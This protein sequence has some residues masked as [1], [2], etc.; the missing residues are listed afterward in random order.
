MAHFVSEDFMVR[1]QVLV[2]IFLPMTCQPERG[3]SF[4]HHE[5][6]FRSGDAKRLRANLSQTACLTGLSPGHRSYRPDAE[7]TYHEHP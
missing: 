1:R 3:V 7:R 5:I 6:F 2:G 4:R